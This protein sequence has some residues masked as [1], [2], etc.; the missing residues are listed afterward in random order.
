MKRL[1]WAVVVVITVVVLVAETGFA[2]LIVARATKKWGTVTLERNGVDQPFVNGMDIENGDII[3]TDRGSGAVY[4]LLDKDGIPFGEEEVFGLPGPDGCADAPGD[5]GRA[6]A[7]LRAKIIAGEKK[8]IITI[9]KKGTTKFDT[10]PGGEEKAKSHEV[11]LPGAIARKKGTEYA[12]SYEVD[13]DQTSL[14]TLD[15]L[16]EIDNIEYS[17]LPDF[18]F[19]DP[20]N[21]SDDTLNFDVIL[22]LTNMTNGAFDLLGAGNAVDVG[23][24]YYSIVASPP[25]TPLLGKAPIHDADGGL[26]PEPATI[27]LLVIGGL[28]MLRHRNR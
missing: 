3:K 27:G 11:K 1:H 16:V 13:I 9:V 8:R 12:I 21:K 22:G 25:S 17:S 15:G 10:N 28:V 24:G 19:T 14:S 6:E 5:K 26:S 23:A 7:E 4:E 2:D 20:G 18:Y